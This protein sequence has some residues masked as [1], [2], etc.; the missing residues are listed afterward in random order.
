MSASSL[1][2]FTVAELNKLGLKNKYLLVFEMYL[3]DAKRL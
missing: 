1:V 3:F 2:V